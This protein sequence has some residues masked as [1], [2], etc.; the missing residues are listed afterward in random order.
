MTT[1]W[2]Q[3]SWKILLL[4]GVLG[5]AF[6]VAV[7]VWPIETVTVLVVL[8]GC[9]ALVDGIG[10][11]AQ[12]FGPGTPG[13]ARVLLGAMGLV[14]LVVAVFAIFRP[15]ETA[16]ALTWILGIWLVVRGGF[17][18]AGAFSASRTT[19]R[20]LILLGAAVDLL[21]GILF[22]L[23]PGSA[24]VGIAWVLGLVALLWGVIFLV[25]GF[26]VRREAGSAPAPGPVAPA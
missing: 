26:L 22:V 4:R 19:S 3:L 11:F 17:E 2:L 1:D 8:W 16:T 14:A 12:A 20:G 10:A 24:A 25:T 9:W 18:L 5:V 7:M 21:L 15:I 23:N 13:G 6:G